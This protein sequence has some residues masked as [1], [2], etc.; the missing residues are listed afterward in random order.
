MSGHRKGRAVGS[1]YH[2]LVGAG[3]A[4]ITIL[5]ACGGASTAADECRGLPEARFA[6]SVS[7]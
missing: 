3:A 1:R 5:M 4:F 7:T 6:V 2:Y